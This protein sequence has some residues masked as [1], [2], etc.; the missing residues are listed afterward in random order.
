MFGVALLFI[1]NL[2]STR[3]SAVHVLVMCGS[4]VSSFVTAITTCSRQLLCVCV[5]VCVCV[6]C[7]YVHALVWACKWCVC[8]CV[9]FMLISAVFSKVNALFQQ[10]TLQ[11]GLLSSVFLFLHISHWTYI[12]TPSIVSCQTHSVWS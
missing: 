2:P 10:C 4:S 12:A 1:V 7:V 8:L 3:L 11:I 5:C 9:C 6:V